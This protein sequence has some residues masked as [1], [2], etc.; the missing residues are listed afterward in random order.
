MLDLSLIADQVAYAANR[1][2][3]RRTRNAEETTLAV[4]V[5]NTWSSAPWRDQVERIRE[6][7]TSWLVAHSGPES[8]PE[9]CVEAPPIPSQYAVVATDGSQIAPD[10]HDG[11]TS[12]W[13]LHI[14]RVLLIYGTGQRPRLDASAEVLI[15]E[16]DDEDQE[17]QEQAALRGLGARRFAREIKA[18]GDLAA[19]AAQMPLPAIALTD[20]SLIAWT[21]YDEEGRDPAKEEG[22]QAL[23]ATLKATQALQIP[24]VGYVSLPQSRDIIN[25][26][27]ITLC[28]EVIVN[29]ERCPYPKNAKPCAPIRHTTDAALFARILK[30][31]ERSAVFTSWGQK[32][33]FSQILP[34]AYGQ[35]HWIA[36]FYLNVGAEIVRI[37][38]PR[39]AA[40]VPEIV[41]RIHAIC[42]DQ[43]KKGR[44]YPV[45]LA[46]A[47]E[48]AIVRG[49][50]RAA[51]LNLLNRHLV[52]IG[53]P[54]TQTRKA[55]A[56]QARAV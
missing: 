18:L 15:L 10:R 41:Q 43:A 31:G 6:A 36:F 24:L 51:F 56:K 40:E 11:V 52:K 2:T 16:E 23:Q 22:L 1:E 13:L 37:E 42:L 35:D 30:P 38:I 44:G 5:A 28:P 14:G 9:D 19:E 25:A 53:S 47:H 29:C 50:D 3:E 39:W 20:G 12:C 34:I 17:E 46:E 48:R 33:G 32:T 45:A 54:T 26:L 7:R 8:P 55:L 21:L 49:A 4:A 27:R